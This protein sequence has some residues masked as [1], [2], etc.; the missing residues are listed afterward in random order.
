MTSKGDNQLTPMKLRERVKL[1][2]RQIAQA[3]D[4]RQGTVSDWE[5]GISVPRL[6]PS[7]LK[8]MMEIYDCSVDELIEAFEVSFA[9]RRADS[10]LNTT[11]A[12]DD[13][14]N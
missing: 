4:V 2:Q 13:L 1:T 11:S 8:K 5:R 9:K 7:K 6:S 12:S 10:A 3:L 14:L